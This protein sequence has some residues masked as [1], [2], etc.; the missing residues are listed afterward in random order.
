[1]E[2]FKTATTNLEIVRQVQM[3]YK[4][5]VRANSGVAIRW[6]GLIKSMKRPSADAIKP[7]I[8]HDYEL[9]AASLSSSSLSIGT[10]C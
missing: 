7:A 1:M 6:P 3:K 10:H 8:E 4:V 2:L 5:D 9:F